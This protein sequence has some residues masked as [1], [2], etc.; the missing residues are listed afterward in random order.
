MKVVFFGT[1]DFVLP[2]LE[3]LHQT[4]NVEIAAVVTAPDQPVGR[5][6]IL[7]TTPVK[8]WAKQ[9]HISV[10]DSASL[11]QIIEAIQKIKPQLGILAAYGKIIPPKLMNLFPKGILVIHPSL[12]PKYRG[13]T[14]VPVAIL[15]GEK[16]T[17]VTI[18]KMDEKVDH[19][20]IVAQ[21]KDEI[22]PEDTAETLLVRLFAAVAESLVTILPAYVENRIKMRTQDNRQATYT[23][24]LKRE[25]GYI[26]LESPPPPETVDRMIRAYHPWPGVW[27]WVE[28]PNKEKPGPKGPEFIQKRLKILKAHLEEK[29]VFNLI[30]F[31][32]KQ[33]IIDQVQLEGKKPVSFKEFLNG[34][35]EMKKRIQKIWIND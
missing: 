26:D 7:T 10:I 11:I 12:L 33:L 19:G 6:G 1:P 25:D 29:P 18:I 20:P 23:K 31:N 28:I 8:I 24:I 32:G 3:A 9:K 2:I 14:P 35:P 27:T 15:A 13:P 21:F 17:G 22:K 30:S 16:E 4:K 34:Y 5:H